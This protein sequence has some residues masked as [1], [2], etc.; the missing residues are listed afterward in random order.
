MLQLLIICG[1]KSGCLHVIYKIEFHTKKTSKTPYELRKDH[2]PNLKYL[3]VWRCLAKVMLPDP[4]KRKIRSKTYDCMFIG[5]ASNTAT[6][7][8]IILKSDVL[9]CNIII[10][11][12]NA[13]FFEHIFPLSE[14]I[15]YTSTIVDD[16]E[17]LYDE[18]VPTT[19]DDMKSSHDEL[20]MSKRQIKEV[21]FGD[22]FYTYLIENELSSYFEAISSS[23][24]LLRK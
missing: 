19:V 6:Y 1:V 11:T 18:H 13:E 9:K 21:S 24:A 16:I 8:F 7:R 14:K 10:K 22:D 12:T 4:K 20:R 3:K 15:S 17:N 5:Y 23:D 2:T